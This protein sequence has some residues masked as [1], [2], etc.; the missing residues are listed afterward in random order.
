MVISQ[1][2]SSMMNQLWWIKYDE[3]I[4]VI[5][6]DGGFADFAILYSGIL[7]WRLNIRNEAEWTLKTCSDDS[8]KSIKVHQEEPIVWQQHIRGNI[9]SF[10]F[11]TL[12]RTPSETN[13]RWVGDFCEY[14]R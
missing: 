11:R 13:A 5:F 12:A 6:G 3:L 14:F 10:S 1:I 9:T 7:T 8:R 4:I 2:E